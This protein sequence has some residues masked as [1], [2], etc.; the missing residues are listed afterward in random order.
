M[1]FNRPKLNLTIDL[2]AFVCAVLM[3]VTGF[4][5]E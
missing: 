1:R 5:L 2:L 3:V 4:L